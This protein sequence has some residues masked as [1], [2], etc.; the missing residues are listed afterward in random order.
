MKPIKLTMEISLRNEKNKIYNKIN[1]NINAKRKASPM[2]G[3]DISSKMI[4]Q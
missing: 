2:S 4:N 1:F 3:H